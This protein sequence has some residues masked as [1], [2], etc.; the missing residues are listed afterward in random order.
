MFFVF[1]ILYPSNNLLP[2]KKPLPAP[3]GGRFPYLLLTII[4]C[5]RKINR[6]LSIHF[7]FLSVYLNFCPLISFLLIFFCIFVANKDLCKTIYYDSYCSAWH[8]R[9]ET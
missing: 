5:R 8:S 6:F 7:S 2:C 1:F 4:I 9:A 3:H